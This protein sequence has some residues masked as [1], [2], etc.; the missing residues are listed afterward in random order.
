[1]TDAISE[2]TKTEGWDEQLPRHDIEILVSERDRLK[3]A[4]VKLAEALN[5]C[6]GSLQDLRLELSRHSRR[7]SPPGWPV[8]DEGIAA[9]KAHGPAKEP[10]P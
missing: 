4:N 7:Q 3:A 5:N 2:L 6:V 8:I 1:M 9:L 10:T